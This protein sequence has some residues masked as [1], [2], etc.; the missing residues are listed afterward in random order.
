MNPQRTAERPRGERALLAASR[1]YIEED[2]RAGWRHTLV[3]FSALA[4]TLAAIVWL[5]APWARAPLSV[6]AGLL[7]VRCFILYHDYMHGSLLRGSKLAA[8]LFRAYG[9]LTLNPPRIWR[10]THNYHHLHTARIAGS[11]IGSYPVVTTAQW[12]RMS[13]R[14]R[15]QYRL[16]RHPL[17]IAAGYVTVFL[18]GMCLRPFLRRPRHNFDSGLALALHLLLLWTAWRL[19][20]AATMLFAVILPQAVASALGAYIFYVQH[21]FPEVEI[22]GRREW[23]YAEAALHASAF[24]D[25]GPV[26][27]WFFGNIGFHHVHHLNPRIPFYRL[28]EAM[29]QIPELRDP[30]RTTLGWRDVVTSFRLKVWDPERNEMVGFPAE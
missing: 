11:H 30:P 25:M 14:Q 19:G 4:A 9:V 27:R 5:D 20:G 6:L 3:G 29:E 13:P 24:I 10:E 17:T 21:N 22:R 18:A 2:R 1:P 26:A 8:V 15:L 16:T 28:P 23:T 7:T 12:R